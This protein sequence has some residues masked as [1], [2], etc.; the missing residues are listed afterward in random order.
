MNRVV[1]TGRL[2]KDPELKK[3]ST[4]KSVCDFSI[5]VDEYKKEE[6]APANWINCQAWNAQAEYLDNYAWCGDKVLVEGRVSNSTYEL[7]GETKYFFRVIVERLELFK[8][9]KKDKTP[10]EDKP[11]KK[12]SNRDNSNELPF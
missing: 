11:K 12:E 7:N 5:A 9:K 6:G 3:T 8:E 4:G 10:K 1:L 2:G